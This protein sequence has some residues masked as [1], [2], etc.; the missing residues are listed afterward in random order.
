[1]L[2]QIRLLLE[3]QH[4]LLVLLA[5]IPLL[6]TDKLLFP[7]A[8]LARLDVIPLLATDKRRVLC[9]SPVPLENSTRG[10]NPPNFA[11]SVPPAPTKIPPVA[12]LAICVHWENTSLLRTRRSTTTIRPIAKS[13]VSFNSIHWKAKRNVIYV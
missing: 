11:P 7:I 3:L 9:A 5:V 10:E 13:V 8:L 6:E 2:R 1:M 4:A 12:P